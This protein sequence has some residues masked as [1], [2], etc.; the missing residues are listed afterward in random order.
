LR[1][2]QVLCRR[3]VDVLLHNRLTLAIMLGAPALVVARFLVL[4]RPGAFDPAGGDAAAAVGTTYW[5]AFAAFFF[6]LTYGLLQI[7]TEAAVVRRERH[8]G[9]GLGAY[10]LAKVGVLLPVLLVVIA[11]MV[12]ALRATGR[13]PGAP[14]RDDAVVVGILLLDAAAALALGLL[15]SAA[16]VDPSH[17]TLALPMLCFP[18]VLF[19]GAVLPVHLMAG[20]GRAISVVTADRWAFEALGRHLALEDRFGADAAG[21]ALGDQYGGAFSGGSGTGLLALGLFALAFLA[22]AVAT[23]RRRT[24]VR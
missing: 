21:R 11:A 9:L 3:N 17:A 20:A 2:W 18:A 4:F 12:A 6:G 5:L 19:G 8:V 24:A 14:W 16:V 15:A 7:C 22:A 23:L 10:V 13:L 1:Q